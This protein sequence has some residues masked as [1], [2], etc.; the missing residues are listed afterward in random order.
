MQLR[1]QIESQFLPYVIKPGRYIGNELGAIRKDAPTSVSLALAFPDKYELAMSHLGLQIIYKLVNDLDFA[2]CER[3]FAPDIDA[4]ARLRELKLPLFSLES[5]Q[6]LREFDLVGFSISYELGYTNLLTM[7]EL[8]QIPLHSKERT[9]DDPIV[10]AG[11]PSCFNPEPMAEFIDF[12]FIGEVESSIEEILRLV[13]R[14]S[15][16]GRVATLEALAKLPGIYVPAFYDAKYDAGGKFAGLEKTNPAAPDTVTAAVNPDISS[17]FYSTQPIVPFEEVTHDRLSVEIMRGCGH[18]CR[19]CQAGVIYRPKRDRKVDDIVNYTVRTLKTT[20][21]DEITLL[22][23]SSSD[24]KKLDDLIARL[25]AELRGKHVKISLPSLRPTMRS[26]E[27]AKQISPDDR[28]A[29]TFALEG[30]TERMREVINKQ[31]GIEEFFRVVSSAFASGWRLLKLYFMIGLPTETDADLR[32]IVDVVRNCERISRKQR[33]RGTINVTISPLSPKA[34]TPWQWERQ[35]EIAEIRE[36]NEMLRRSCRSRSVQL[37]L[38]DPELSYL[39]GVISRGD[40]RLS[41]VIERAQQLGAR[42]DGWSEHFNFALWQQA[43]ADSGID[44][45][46]YAEARDYN[47]PLPWD[48][49]DK[50][51]K[52]DWLWRERERAY[53]VQEMPEPLGGDF[54]LSDL[55]QTQTPAAEELLVAQPAAPAAKFGRKPKRQTGGTAV[56]VPRSKIR[57]R[58]GKGPEVRFLGH[59][60]V[61]RMFERAIRRAQIP[62]AYTQGFHPRQRLSLGPPL[63]L[64]FTS[65]AEYLDLQLDSPFADAMIQNLNESLPRGFTVLEGRPLMGKS[66]SLT[67]VINLA[68]YVVDLPAGHTVTNDRIAEVIAAE[69][70]IIKRQ[71]A[72]SEKEVDIRPAIVNLELRGVAERDQLFMELAMGNLGFA[73]PDEVLSNCFDFQPEMVPGLPVHRSELLIWQGGRRQTPF[74]V[75]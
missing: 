61:V 20:G 33:G 7:L 27:L 39:E 59:L 23:L 11:G 9:E 63:T 12:F 50:G 75:T 47:D 42:F 67:S 16:V 41:T 21:Y 66:P 49:I 37:K 69:S 74:E 1:Q 62:V 25:T 3:V 6:P 52:K 35:A 45:Q 13:Q 15:E 68:S 71:R 5:F 38:R 56:T 28:P 31:V 60:A 44:P 48:H 72:D 14:K 17:E 53:A 73:R 24:F 65:E 46:T 55:I 2:R 8:S 22:S 40:R 29:L 4:E 58:W 19:F 64:G 54:N 18:G 10:C 51:V 36:K 26:L 43:F 32:G 70:L 34:H 30:G 57:L